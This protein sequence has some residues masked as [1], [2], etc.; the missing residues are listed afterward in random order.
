MQHGTPT[1][2]QT[3][4]ALGQYT[5]FNFGKDRDNYEKAKLSV[6]RNRQTMKEAERQVRFDVT[7]KFY[8]LKTKQDLL[9]IS[10]RT[11]TSAKAVVDLIR[12]RIAVGK[13]KENDLSSAE[14]DLLTA[15][16]QFLGDETVY[17]QT[18][19][20]LNTILGDGINH[21]YLVKAKIDFKKMK[22]TMEEALKIFQ[23]NSPA[24]RDAKASLEGARI[25]YRL[26][27][28]NSLPLPTVTFSGITLGYA[29]GNTKSTQIRDT[30]GA[31]TSGN[32][33]VSAGLSFTIP[34]LGPTGF[35]GGRT[36]R[37]AE[38]A[39]EKAEIAMRLASNTTEISVR[40]IFTRFAQQEEQIQNAQKIYKDAGKIFESALAGLQGSANLN[41][42]DLKDAITQLR[43]AEQNFTNLVLSHYGL[44]LQLSS[45]I[46]VDEFPE[47]KL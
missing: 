11:V 32:L 38:I 40:D 6:E 21:K 5:L 39:E 15:Q 35:L 10:K 46:G 31:S 7:S 45:T 42:L 24:M 8:E 14:V 3:T 17:I 28:K 34:L 16:N 43:T 19:W 25:D 30:T 2:T 12:S 27:Q 1:G 26:A 13:A 18:L 29:M 44:K 41:R 9:D 37:A 22:L 47:D 36:R 23:L 4:L 33:D 20:A